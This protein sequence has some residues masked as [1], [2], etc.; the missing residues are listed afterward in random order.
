MDVAE[1]S[2]SC[3]V[4]EVPFR[5]TNCSISHSSN[6]NIGK[7]KPHHDGNLVV[8]EFETNGHLQDNA[9]N[10]V[11]CPEQKDHSWEI[12]PIYDCYTPF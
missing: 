3:W 12:L 9:N 1:F 10:C 8:G 4:F 6:D 7:D 2:I 11:T 5:G